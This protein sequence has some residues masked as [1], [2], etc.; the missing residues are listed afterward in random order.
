VSDLERLGGRIAEDERWQRDLTS[1]DAEPLLDAALSLLEA[2]LAV[3]TPDDAEA[4]AYQAPYRESAAGLIREALA[5]AA[6]SITHPEEAAPILRHGLAPLYRALALPGR[7]SYEAKAI[8][9][10][11]N[12]PKEG[13]DGKR[14]AELLRPDGGG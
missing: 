10:A 2:A 9:L 14:L 3:Y 12:L 11:D 13:L 5:L 4:E 8:K 1:D 7:K 6:R